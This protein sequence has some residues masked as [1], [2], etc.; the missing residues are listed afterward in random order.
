[1]VKFF[2]AVLKMATGDLIE[3]CEDAVER[4]LQLRE[5]NQR[6]T[7]EIS[8]IQTEIQR[9]APFK[10]DNTSNDVH[11]PDELICMAKAFAYLDQPESA[12]TQTDSNAAKFDF[13]YAVGML[14]NYSPPIENKAKNFLEF[15]EAAKDIIKS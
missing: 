11:I 9:M 8:D 2:V 15:L 13:N 12:R 7:T 6:L 1:M 14:K 4:V 10:S 5:A 3:T